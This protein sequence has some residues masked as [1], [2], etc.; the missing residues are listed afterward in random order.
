MER[1]EKRFQAQIKSIDKENHT[2]TVLV[3][4]ATV[5][6]DGEVIDP[7]G[8]EIENYLKNPVLL[9][10][11]NIWGGV[12]EIL[13]KAKSLQKTPEGLVATF[14]YFVGKGNEAADYAWSLVEAGL[15]AYSVSFIPKEWTDINEGDLRRKYTR[16][17]LL[18]IS[19]V[20]VPANPA[21][22]LNAVQHGD[23]AMIEAVIK[24]YGLVHGE[25]K[26]VVPYKKHPWLPDD[27][28]WDA[29]KARKQFLE[30]AG[31]KD[32]FDPAK[33]RLGFAWYDKE[34]KENVTA[35]KLPH[36]YVENGDIK[37]VWRGVTAA[38]AALL[39]ARGG[40]A[41]PE[42]EKE[43]VYNHLAKHYKDHGTE[44]PPLKKYDGD[45]TIYSMVGA[46]TL[47]E[48]QEIDVAVKAMLQEQDQD[49]AS[50]EKDD[51]KKMILLELY[52]RTKQEE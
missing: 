25:E 4:S 23:K 6:R 33:Y 3:S 7:Q 27:T 21:A 39:G 51:P 52:R 20:S 19:H 11:H 8:W 42:N 35:Y 34:H 26:T 24:A 50:S 45:L 28:K 12:K 14:Q 13:G 31:G 38:M 15:A 18:E 9:N 22:V 46:K 49:V 1:I 44:P 47:E 17:E 5:D 29:N 30:Y 41:I 36:H 48:A 40:V 16:Q 43:A 2:V 32:N 10:S 37:T